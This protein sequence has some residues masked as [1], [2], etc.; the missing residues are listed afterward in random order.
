VWPD[1]LHLLLNTGNAEFELLRN[2]LQYLL[3]PNGSLRAGISPT[4]GHMKASSSSKQGKAWTAAGFDLMP[5]LGS[6]DR[7]LCSRPITKFHGNQVDIMF[8]MR[9]QIFQDLAEEFEAI[10]ACSTFPDAIRHVPDMLIKL[11][12]LL[13][14]C[15][16]AANTGKLMTVAQLDVLQQQTEQLKEPLRFFR[17]TEY[18]PLKNSIKTYD[19]ICLCHLVPIIREL[20]DYGMTMG[21]ASSRFLEHMNGLA[22]R[23]MHRQPGRLRSQNMNLSM[24][25]VA[26]TFRRL[27]ML[28]RIKRRQMYRRWAQA[29][30]APISTPQ[31]DTDEIMND[32]EPVL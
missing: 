25:P 2:V 27:S 28:C 17:D 14:E 7:C 8:G 5:V 32:V 15:H 18:L 29:P 22:K 9:S 30:E 13:S 6:V 31:I 20:Q 12:D 16:K 3:L 1:G 26:R 4:D 19:H 10:R 11:W 23:I 24:D 21:T